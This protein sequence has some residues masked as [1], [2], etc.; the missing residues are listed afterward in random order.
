MLGFMQEH[1][2]WVLPDGGTTLV[3]NEY[4]W[5][6]EA[7]VLYI[8]QPAGVGFST[9][10]Q[11]SADCA[12]DDNSS[13]E[14]NLKVVLAWFEKFPEFKANDLYISG[15]SYAGIYVPY[16]VNA[17]HHYNQEHLTDSQ[18]KPN[19]KGMMVGN[20]VT[21]W[22]Y[23]TE[24]AYIEMAYWHRLFDDKVYDQMLEKNCDYSGVALGR[25][26]TGD[27]LQLYQD[28]TDSVTTI[29]MYDIFGTCWGAKDETNPHP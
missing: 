6:K 12:H 17:I 26:P 24:P 14:D 16:L 22:K 7:N 28:F 25:L 5:N 4:A 19:L 13:A 8:E 2:P 21:N 27:C 1:G 29:N 15:E 10:D 3:R 20:G 9:C 23:D 11:G 18:F